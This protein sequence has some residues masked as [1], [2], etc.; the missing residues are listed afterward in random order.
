MHG[1][2]KLFPFEYFDHALVRSQY[3]LLQ[4]L[5]SLCFLSQSDLGELRGP[6]SRCR[7]SI[8][9]HFRPFT[10]VIEKVRLEVSYKRRL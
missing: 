2:A 1:V 9:V 5:P 6:E 7:G 10:L 3:S 4:E 8:L